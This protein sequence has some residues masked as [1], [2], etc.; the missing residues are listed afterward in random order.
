M[1]VPKLLRANSV[2]FATDLHSASTDWAQ[3]AVERKMR[4]GSGVKDT[5][6][7]SKGRHRGRWLPGW[8]DREVFL[9]E[10]A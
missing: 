3:F 4:K 8:K 5:Q 7:D 6:R 10:G 9:E 2:L 1:T